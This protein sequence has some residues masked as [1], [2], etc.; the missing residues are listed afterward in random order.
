MAPELFSKNPEAVKATDIW[1]FGATLFEL[2]NGELPFYGQGG[3]ML[4]KGAEIPELKGAWSNDLRKTVEACLAKQPWDRP[5]AKQLEAYAAK[6]VAGNYEKAPWKNVK[7]DSSATPVDDPG[8]TVRVSAGRLATSSGLTDEERINI[9]KTCQNRSFDMKTGTLCGLTGQKPDFQTQCNNLIIDEKEV[10]KIQKEKEEVQKSVDQIGGWT[11]F[12]LWCGIGL[13]L[14]ISTI[15]TFMTVFTPGMDGV[16]IAYSLVYLGLFLLIGIKAILAFYRKQENA[17]P[18][19]TAYCVMIALDA[20]FLLIVNLIVKQPDGWSSVIRN[21]IW[22]AIWLTYL[23]SSED[24]KDKFPKET[25]KWHTLEK[26]VLAIVAALF[27]ILTIIIAVGNKSNDPAPVNT[28]QKPAVTVPAQPTQN[29]GDNS[30]PASVT[31]PAES[32][33]NTSSNTGSNQSQSSSNAGSSK[34]ATTESADQPST[35]DNAAKLQEAVRK[36]DYASVRKLADS[37]YSPAYLPLARYYLQNP[38]THDLA[39]SYAKKAKRA[40]VRGAQ[41]IID[42]LTALG[43]YD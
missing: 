26:V 3:I 21:V 2:I 1:A 6:C 36:G 15:R 20:I 37:G 40:G 39:D 31:K 19:A 4:E 13:G 23:Y 12:F 5:T 10:E 11:A 17:V 8:K 9:C 43:Y 34:P 42:D 7:D 24:I 35:D 14:L 18:L 22:A 38:S 29:N 28:P 33:G 27:L 30:A 32:K 25:R 41:D 16:T